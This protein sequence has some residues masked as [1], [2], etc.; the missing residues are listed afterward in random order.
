[1]TQPALPELGFSV[2]HMSGMPWWV[3]VII[4]VAIGLSFWWVSRFGKDD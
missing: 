2:P 1:M 4:L 3:S